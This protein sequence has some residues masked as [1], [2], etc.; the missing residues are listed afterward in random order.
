[1][2]PLVL[3]PPAPAVEILGVATAFSAAMGRSGTAI[4]VRDPAPAG[5]PATVH[6]LAREL[7]TQ[8]TQLGEQ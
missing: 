6:P 2:V 1:M 7:E 4:G 3:H 5:R 8:A